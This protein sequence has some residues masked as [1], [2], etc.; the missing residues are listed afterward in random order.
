[1]KRLLFT[2]MLIVAALAIWAQRWTPVNAN[3]YS[4]EAIVYVQVTISGR[5]ATANNPL[6]VSAFMDDK[7]RAQ[8]TSIYTPATNTGPRNC[9]C[10]RIPGNPQEDANKAITFK[11]FY[12][13]LVYIFSETK[14]WTDTETIQPVPVVL[15]LEPL[16]NVQIDPSAGSPI[17]IEMDETKN[18]ASLMTLLYGN[19]KTES[20]VT[21]SSIDSEETEIFFSWNAGNYVIFFDIDNDGVITPKQV[22]TQ[23][24]NV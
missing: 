5:V 17:T 24:V 20:E 6:E 3:S 12:N 22:T 18:M 21:D 13:G 23:T 9:Y 14:K 10:L 19:G 16:T 4:S 8:S 7:C 11:V 1:M 2:M 15:N